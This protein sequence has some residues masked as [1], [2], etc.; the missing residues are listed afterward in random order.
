[1][2]TQPKTLDGAIAAVCDFWINKMQ[3]PVN[4]NNGDGSPSGRLTF[5]LM[6][7]L[8]QKAQDTI[9]REKI[10]LFRT[11]LTNTIKTEFNN[12]HYICDVDYHPSDNLSKACKDA[13]ID[14]MALPCKSHTNIHKDFTVQSRYQYGGDFVKLY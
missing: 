11:S 10:E 6:N 5:M 13:N 2:D 1:M 9:S 7:L 8:G 12:G 3:T 4:Q 14:T